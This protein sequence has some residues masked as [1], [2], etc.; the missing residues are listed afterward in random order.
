MLE[1][2]TE[3]RDV[4]FRGG[5][6][7]LLRDW[8]CHSSSFIWRFLTFDVNCDITHHSLF[9]LWVFFFF[10]NLKAS[11]ICFKKTWQYKS[12]EVTREWSLDPLALVH[13]CIKVLGDVTQGC[14]WFGECALIHRDRGMLA[15][16]EAWSTQTGPSSS[17][18][19][20]NLFICK[21]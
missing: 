6:L 17:L 21:K 3:V 4:S 13:K 7:L 2:K 1:Q 18:H 16:S 19:C 20:R 8:Y 14:G 12:W 10:L 15:Y 9:P 11:K 5:L